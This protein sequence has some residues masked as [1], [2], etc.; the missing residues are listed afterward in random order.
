MYRGGFF[1]SRIERVALDYIGRR[2]S[3]TGITREKRMR[4]ARDILQK[5]LLPNITQQEGFET[6]KAFFLGYMVHR[7]LLSCALDRQDPDDRD[8]FGKK[9]LDLAG[10]LL[11]QLF[12]ILFKK[13]TR[14]IYRYM[15]KCVET[16]KDFNLTLAVKSNTIT[17]GLK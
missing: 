12:R 14:D 13:L 16:N 7:L 15:Q 3:A 4:Y 5:E 17:N 11:A 10:P 2:G 8:H 1:L 9:R 6:R